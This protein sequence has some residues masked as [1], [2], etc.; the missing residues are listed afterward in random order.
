MGI[1]DRKIGSRRDPRNY[2]TSVE[3]QA[4]ATL[5][6]CQLE[7]SISDF[8]VLDLKDLVFKSKTMDSLLLCEL[9]SDV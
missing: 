1:S 6:M 9:S 3:N 8:S 7:T 4:L 2:G 5:K